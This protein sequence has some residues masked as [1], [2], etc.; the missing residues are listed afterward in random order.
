MK[1]GLDDTP[2]ALEEAAC[3]VFFLDDEGADGAAD[4]QCVAQQK[5]ENRDAG[6]VNHRRD[7]E[8]RYGSGDTTQIEQV[9]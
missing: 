9:L 6:D 5:A 2:S 4:A 3:L 7:G 8:E 1:S